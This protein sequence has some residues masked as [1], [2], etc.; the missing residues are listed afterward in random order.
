MRCVV[1]LRRLIC[2]PSA[3]L[4]LVQP[5]LGRRPRPCRLLGPR[6]RCRCRLPVPAPATGT[7]TGITGIL[8]FL[9]LHHGRRLAAGTVL[10]RAVAGR[11]GY[12]SFLEHFF[13]FITRNIASMLPIQIALVGMLCQP[14]HALHGHSHHPRAD[15]RMGWLDWLTLEEEDMSPQA[16][17]A[18]ESLCQPLGCVPR[19]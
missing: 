6:Y 5:R 8:D 11:S 10:F 18:F 4:P 9:A 13:I 16:A 3:L 15:V 7:G 17:A 14:R 12:R 1:W 2:A 19:S